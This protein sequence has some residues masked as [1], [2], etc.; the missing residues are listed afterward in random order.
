MHA[1][2]H[3]WSEEVK[4]N[5]LA[6]MAMPDGRMVVNHAIGVL[7]HVP[8]EHEN[9]NGDEWKRVVDCLRKP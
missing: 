1:Y 2:T 3:I 4:G 8:R 7:I 6:H 5:A 9:L